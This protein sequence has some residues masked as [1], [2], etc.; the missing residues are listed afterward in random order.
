M[1]VRSAGQLMIV[2]N[3]L[4]GIGSGIAAAL[5]F[6]TPASGAAL[7]PLL[8]IMAPLPILIAA[9]GWSHWAGSFAVAVAAVALVDRVLGMGPGNLSSQL[10][11]FVCDGSAGRNRRVNRRRANRGFDS[12]HR[13]PG[14]RHAIGC[15]S[16]RYR[17]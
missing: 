15:C 12:L 14:R 4:I 13:F 1:A 2:H 16:A 5:L 6:A 11:R 10:T 8:M 3:L 17:P 7:A 9:I